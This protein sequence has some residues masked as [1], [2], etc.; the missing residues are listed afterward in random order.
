MTIILI[1]TCIAK[2][3]DFLDPYDVS[4]RFLFIDVEEYGI[5][6][7][8]YKNHIYMTNHSKNQKL[9]D[10]VGVNIMLIDT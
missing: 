5:P 9:Y 2:I 10:N 1:K 4:K 6:V 3:A 7:K 8:M